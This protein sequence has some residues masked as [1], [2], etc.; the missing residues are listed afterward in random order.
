MS[1][2]TKTEIDAVT[3]E[4]I[5]R[6]LTADEYAAIEQVKQFPHPTPMPENLPRLIP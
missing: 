1:K 2:L 3:G 4:I 6:E 5:E